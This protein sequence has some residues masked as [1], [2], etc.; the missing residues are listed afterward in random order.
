MNSFFNMS[1]VVR[2]SRC[3]SRAA[4]A[5]AIPPDGGQGSIGFGWFTWKSSALCRPNTRTRRFA[6][7]VPTVNPPESATERRAGPVGGYWC[8]ES[9]E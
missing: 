4:C 2:Q 5:C 7:S 6:F 9:V 3:L 1:A 8:E